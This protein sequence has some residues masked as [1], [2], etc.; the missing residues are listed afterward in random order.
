MAGKLID[1][2]ELA[3]NLRGEIAAGVTDLKA[4]G[5][6]THGLAVMLVGENPASV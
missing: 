5:G 4:K 1:G 2:K 3:K 6:V